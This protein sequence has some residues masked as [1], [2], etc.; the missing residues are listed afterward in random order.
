MT[1]VSVILNNYS[2]RSIDFTK[3]LP[4]YSVYSCITLPV[5]IRFDLD[6]KPLCNKRRGVKYLSYDDPCHSQK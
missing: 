5:D 2:V 6:I 1:N 3:Y 4:R